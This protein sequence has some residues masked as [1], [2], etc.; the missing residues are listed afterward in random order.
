VNSWIGCSKQVRSGTTSALTSALI[1]R[2]DPR[3]ILTCL[4]K[5]AGSRGEVSRGNYRP[6]GS[7]LPPYPTFHPFHSRAKFL[8]GEYSH[9]FSS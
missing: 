6:S 9:A 4:A 3:A 1:I 7:E 2:L 8:R 5:L